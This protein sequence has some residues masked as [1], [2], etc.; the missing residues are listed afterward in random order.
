VCPVGA[1]STSQVLKRARGRRE[2]YDHILIATD[3][4]ELARKGVE[5]GLYLAS[6]LGSRVTI[7]SVTTPLDPSAV[8]AALESGVEDQVSSYDR[9]VA[10]KRKQSFASLEHQASY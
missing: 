2:L 6:R 1:G 7:V 10:L 9:T 3:G 8:Q 4:S 5:H